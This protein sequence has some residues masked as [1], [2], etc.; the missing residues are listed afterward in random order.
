MHGFWREGVT[1]G[2]SD[3]RCLQ[4][5]SVGMGPYGYSVYVHVLCESILH[6]LY[7]RCRCIFQWTCGDSRMTECTVLAL[8]PCVSV[9]IDG[10]NNGGVQGS[11][12]LPGFSVEGCRKGGFTIG[13]A[14]QVMP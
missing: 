7:S 2:K 11:E 10:L 8:L 1:A 5:S 12:V 4:F 14:I 6:Q 13:L 3:E 9:S